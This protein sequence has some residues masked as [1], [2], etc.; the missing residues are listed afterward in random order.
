LAI[1]GAATAAAPTAAPFRKRRRLTDVRFE[2]F[3]GAVLHSGSLLQGEGKQHVAGAD[4]VLTT[5]EHVGLWTVGG[6]RPQTAR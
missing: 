2:F 4:N 1:G 3:I 5:V 6:V